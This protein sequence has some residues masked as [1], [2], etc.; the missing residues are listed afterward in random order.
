MKRLASL[1][2]TA[3]MLSV[4]LCMPA[5]AG[6]SSPHNI[7]GFVSF[8]TDYYW[9]GMTSTDYGP[10]VQ[11]EIDYEHASGFYAGIW[12][13]NIDGNSEGYDENWNTVSKTGN[14]ELD[15]WI[16]YWREIGPIE[17]DLTAT[18]Y[19]FPGNA[20]AGLRKDPNYDDWMA[21]DAEA[22]MIEFHIGL[23]HRFNLPTVPKLYVGYDFTP[24]YFGE[25]GIG[26]HVNAMVELGLPMELIFQF[27][28]GYQYVEGD[29]QTGSDSTGY[30]YGM[31]G[32]DGFD[33]TYLRAGLARE[34]FGLNF[35]L[36][37]HFGVSDEDWFENAY[38]TGYGY[39][40]VKDQLV[41]TATYSF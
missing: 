31:G 40:G 32:T 28:G 20:D 17:L 36:S 1:F 37:Y 16:G 19:A 7:S 5:N 4:L 21:G 26:H 6:E 30:S 10:A 39:A 24:D 33:Y 27:E 13:G 35:D 41:F 34:F 8:G 3:M 38:G 11:G 23:A 22:D 18:Y 14:V 29:K 12:G 25:D 2:L 15:F 9:R